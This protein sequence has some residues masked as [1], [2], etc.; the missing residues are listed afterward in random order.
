MKHS[1]FPIRA[2][3]ALLGTIMLP[4]TLGLAACG[5]EAE[6]EA[7]AI[8]IV[9]SSTVYPFAQKVAEDFV[10]ANEGMVA[11]QI[12]STG[13]GEGIE[14]FCAGEGPETPDIVNA[15]RRMTF[16]EF[17]RCQNNGVSEIIEIKVGRD[18]IAFASAIDE[19]IELKLTPDNVYRALAANPFGEEQTAA[20]WSQIDSSLPD[21]P[22][23]VYGPPATSGTRDALLDIVM[24]P[25][26]NANAAMAALEES[27][28]TAYEQNCHALRADSAYIDQGEQ[29]D[30]IVRKVAN[31][32]RA[33]GVFGFSY[34]EENSD[35][36]KG[37][38]LGGIMPT[39]ETIAD[40]T[41]PGSRPLYIYVKK[42]HIGVTPGIEA[43]LDQWAKSWSAGGPL[44][45]IG[46]VPATDEA[47]ATSAAAI[48]DKTA[49]TLADFE[50]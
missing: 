17:N 48:K 49:L 24:K 31:N 6:N 16:A 12:E 15:S 38:P 21:A 28:A 14:A 29:D 3:A 43:Y 34:L 11:P 33:I 41:Y 39:A 8:T 1:A 26:C 35:Q 25:A 5:G 32:P 22:I 10:A 40:G 27:D 45:A 44:A 50:A 4:A 7:E 13:S 46:L 37:L 2:R 36:V 47:Q 18:G 23:I 30:L 9:G 19:G 42:A 20:T